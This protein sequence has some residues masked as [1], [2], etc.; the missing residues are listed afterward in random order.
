[1]AKNKTTLGKVGSAIA[2]AAMG[3]VHA[4]DKHVVEPVGDALG[5]MGDKDASN[6][7]AG[8][9]VAKKPAAK[10][11]AAK[12]PAVKAPA[13]PAPAAKKTAAPAPKS[14]KQKMMGS[15]ASKAMPK[16]TGK[17]DPPKTAT[18]KKG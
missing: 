15:V 4:A 5:L 1:M 13:P 8:K 16:A 3:V 14:S 18:K 12:K 11:P 7:Q 2:D 10:K 9:P 17:K 6:A